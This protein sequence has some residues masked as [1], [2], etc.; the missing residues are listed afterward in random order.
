MTLTIRLPRDVRAVIESACRETGSRETGGMLFGEHVAEGDFRILQAT[1][2]GTGSFARFV[3]R[4]ADGLG[5]LEKFFHNSNRNYVRFNYLGE[6]HSHPSFSL[7]PSSP[8]DMT[9]FAIVNDPTTGARFAVS[10][11]VKLLA[12]GT[13]DARSFAYFSGGARQ[14]CTLVF[15]K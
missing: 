6:W 8:D 4:L 12:D 2:A 1:R 15:E 13:L 14:G 3:R 10:L 11:I 7:E 9:M 5:Q